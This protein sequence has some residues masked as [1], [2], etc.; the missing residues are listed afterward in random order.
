MQKYF[1]KE[2]EEEEDSKMES[3]EPISKI[4]GKHRDSTGNNGNK[5]QF[6]VEKWMNMPT[7]SKN[8]LNKLVSSNIQLLCAKYKIY[9]SGNKK[10]MIDLLMKKKQQGNM[11]QHNNK[12]PKHIQKSRRTKQ[13]DK[14]EMNNDSNSDEEDDDIDDS[15]SDDP[16]YHYNNNHNKNNAN[17]TDSTNTDTN[18]SVRRYESVLKQKT[19]K[20]NEIRIT[21]GL[22][23]RIVARIIYISN[24]I[25]VKE[26]KVLNVLFADQ[27]GSIEY[28]LWGGD[29][30]PFRFAYKM[31]DSCII[32]CEAKRLSIHGA[33]RINLGS[34]PISLNSKANVDKIINFSSAD[35]EEKKDVP[36]CVVNEKEKIDRIITQNGH[37]MVTFINDILKMPIM[38]NNANIKRNILGLVTYKDKVEYTSSTG[39]RYYIEDKSGVII[40]NV[41]NVN[42]SGTP[43]IEVGSYVFVYR[44]TVEFSASKRT[45]MKE[46]AFIDA[47]YCPT[48]KLQKILDHYKKKFIPT[49]AKPS[50]SR[51]VESVYI[52][53]SVRE[54]NNAIYVHTIGNNF[55]NDYTYC[56][57]SNVQ[58]RQFRQGQLYYV[59]SVAGGRISSDVTDEDV[60]RNP[61]RYEVSYRVLVDFADAAGNTFTAA[62]F[63]EEAEA[64][65]GCSIKDYFY[66]SYDEQRTIQNNRFKIKWDVY[67]ETKNSIRGQN[68]KGLTRIVRRVRDKTSAR[69]NL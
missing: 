18:T 24:P 48:T 61:E 58:L 67:L 42:T 69:I 66:M 11:I 41:Y 20:I 34:S 55:N 32:R 2:E 21:T 3:S 62:L 4:N 53:H 8:K 27:T 46:G 59:K 33:P 29:I 22:Q 56:L 54:Y 52:E 28:T 6:N 19:V 7:W 15:E 60:K 16:L 65:M 51:F 63:A 50:V 57:F 43:N 23:Y 9:E 26:N 36:S 5:E 12:R 14:E 37:A 17:N 1:L 47:Q 49:K 35:I 40:Y 44:G 25:R 39:L 10:Y 68:D 13:S 30:D 64:F 38:G 45:A 31:G